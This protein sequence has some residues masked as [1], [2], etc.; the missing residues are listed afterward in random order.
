MN[1]GRRS[2]LQLIGAAAAAVTLPDV[3]R[4]FP[5]VVSAAA[6]PFVVAWDKWNAFNMQWKGGAPVF[7]VNGKA[8]HDAAVVQRMCR[9]VSRS[10]GTLSARLSFGIGDDGVQFRYRERKQR[11][12]PHVRTLSGAVSSEWV[13]CGHYD[14]DGLVISAPLPTEL[15]T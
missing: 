6:E 11:V 10:G 3:A 1:I 9:L 7:E 14:I 2:F 5:T 15:T 13:M 8:V 12:Q 4:I